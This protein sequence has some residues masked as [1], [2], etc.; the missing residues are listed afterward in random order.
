MIAFSI[1]TFRNCSIL[2]LEEIQLFEVGLFIEEY[3]NFKR[4][5]CVDF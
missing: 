4:F 2:T 3:P 5:T 1:A